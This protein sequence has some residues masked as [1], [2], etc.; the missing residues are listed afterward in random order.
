MIFV[1]PERQ[2]IYEFA[3]GSYIMHPSLVL[4]HVILIAF[5]LGV[6]F[7]LAALALGPF[8]SFFEGFKKH[9]G[10]VEKVMGGLLVVVGAMFITGN[11]TR[12][13]F[14]FQANLP[15]LNQFG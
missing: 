2:R 13:A 11:F 3:D 10:T 8:L 14:W 6:P 12:L 15:F 5:L 4:D 7:L 1:S 9:L